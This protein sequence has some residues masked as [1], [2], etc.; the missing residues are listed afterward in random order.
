MYSL[1]FYAIFYGIMLA[2]ITLNSAF[3]DV[4]DISMIICSW[5]F[6]IQFF[7][8]FKF[9]YLSK[10]IA[11]TNDSKMKVFLNH[12]SFKVNHR[13]L[14]KL[15][16]FFCLGFLYLI[17]SYRTIDLGNFFELIPDFLGKNTTNLALDINYNY[18]NN[19]NQFSKSKIV[20][21]ALSK[22]L[23]IIIDEN[24]DYH[25]KKSANCHSKNQ[26]IQF[27]FNDKV[28]CKKKFSYLANLKNTIKIKLSEVLAVSKN[29]ANG[30]IYS[31]ITGDKSHID[32]NHLATLRQLGI[33][34]IASVSGFHFAVLLSIINCL[35]IILGFLARYIVSW[36]II[37][38]F[39]WKLIKQII[40]LFLGF[41][42]LW[43]VGF[44][45]SAIR[46]YLCYVSYL[47][48]SSKYNYWLVKDK[49]KIFKMQAEDKININNDDIDIENI[50]NK[51]L[52]M[53]LLPIFLFFLVSP[54]DFLSFSSM[55]SWSSYLIIVLFT[56]FFVKALKTKNNHTTQINT[57]EI[58]INDISLKNHKLD[59]L[60]SK[61]SKMIKLFIAIL[62]LQILLCLNS[63]AM[64]GELSILS[65]LSNM[66]ILFVL[67]LIIKLYV[68][69]NLLVLPLALLIGGVQ[70]LVNSYLAKLLNFCFLVSER[71]I[72]LFYLKHKVIVFSADFNSIHV[73]LVDLI[74]FISVIIMFI[75]YLK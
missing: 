62:I 14:S 55:L 45:P 21:V 60:K 11:Y 41:I 42:W 51:K 71:I 12:L 1:Y 40:C 13:I 69:V 6:F 31:V 67:I 47:F 26:T 75:C 15:M 39:P 18:E 54:L 73:F 29:P 53:I 74:G 65:V 5:L 19:L 50:T 9:Y 48:L 24:G 27:E 68:I 17:F 49:N 22:K 64:I 25:I 4:V 52:L 63:L 38:Y 70:V 33:Y 34:H 72:D 20:T 61:L 56:S 43:F 7:K 57:N 46:A 2:L 58:D 30:F 8:R 59:F 66:T 36:K 28:I 16:V 35:F 23:V 10:L 44:L 3:I 37:I 32:I